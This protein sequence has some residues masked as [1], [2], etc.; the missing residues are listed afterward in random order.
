MA[1]GVL[2]VTSLLTWPTD[3]IKT[4]LQIHNVNHIATTDSQPLLNQQQRTARPSTFSIARSAYQTEG[5]AVFFRGI[6][7]CSARAFIVNAVQW[8]VSTSYLKGT[9]SAQACANLALSAGL[10]VDHEK[11]QLEPTAVE[12]MRVNAVTIDRHARPFVLPVTAMRRRF[13]TRYL[14]LTDTLIPTIYIPYTIPTTSMQEL[15][16][17]SSGDFCTGN[18]CLARL[19]RPQ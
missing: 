18:Y 1:V 12:R 3:V 13:D 2:V 15:L 17:R 16:S 6:G 11:S 14:R 19:F 8:G 4:R 10:R 7:I 5:A 9:N